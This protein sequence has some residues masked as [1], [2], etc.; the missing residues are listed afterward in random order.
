MSKV[1]QEALRRL[2]ISIKRNAPLVKRK[3][4][5]SGARPDAAVVYATAKYYET[6][7]RLAKE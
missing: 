3:L 7:K 2:Q 1:R 5:E 6:L 4:A